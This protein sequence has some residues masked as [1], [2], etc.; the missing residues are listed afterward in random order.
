MVWAAIQGWGSGRY[1]LLDVA[2]TQGCAVQ[3]GEHSQYFLITVNGK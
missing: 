3:H 1:K 2:Y